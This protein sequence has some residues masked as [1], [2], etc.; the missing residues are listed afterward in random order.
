MEIIETEDGLRSMP[1]IV[2]FN[3]IERTVGQAVKNQMV[4]NPNNT[5]TAIER[6]IGLGFSN[7]AVQD[8]IDRLLCKVVDRDGHPHAEVNWEGKTMLLSPEQ[9]SAMILTKLKNIA[10]SYLGFGVNDAVI[11]VPAYFSDGQPRTTVDAGRRASLNVLRIFNE[12]TAA[13]LPYGLGVKGK[14][15]VVVFDLG[16]GTLYVS[17]VE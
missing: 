2:P 8:D 17:V 10:E 1:S 14:R 15:N 5:V 13:A 6:L 16:G 12:P 11:T 9:I 4:E 7:M 3:G